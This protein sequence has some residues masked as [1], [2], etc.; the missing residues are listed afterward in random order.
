[1]RARQQEAC[2][3]LSTVIK[4]LSARQGKLL[5]MMG[6]RRNL[7]SEAVGELRKPVFQEIRDLYE[8]ISG[9]RTVGEEDIG[10]NVAKKDESRS[11]GRESGVTRQAVA[12]SGSSEAEVALFSTDVDGRRGTEYTVVAGSGV[13]RKATAVAQ[14]AGTEGCLH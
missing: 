13:T 10:R 14:N 4:Y 5:A 12:G 8:K 3:E 7:M 6:R 11:G 9:D 2:Q 1:M